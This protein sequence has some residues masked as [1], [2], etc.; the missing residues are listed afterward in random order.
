VVGVGVTSAPSWLVV[1]RPFL[2]VIHERLSGTILFIGQ[3]NSL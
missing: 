2:L 1:D 3:I